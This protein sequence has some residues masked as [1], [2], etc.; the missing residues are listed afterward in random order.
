MTAIVQADVTAFAPE[1][2]T[3]LGASAWTDVLLYVNELDLTYLTETDQVT[4]MARIYLAAHIGTMSWR[5]GSAAAGPLT[6]EAVGGVRRSYGLISMMTTQTA[7]G[8]T[9]YGQ[10]YLDILTMSFAHG[11]LVL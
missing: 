7:L 9:R 5:G 4:R 10:M 11:P 1:L 6:G 8:S 3:K 2:A